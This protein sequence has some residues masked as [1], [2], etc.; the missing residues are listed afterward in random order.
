M[1]QSGAHLRMAPA[2]APG[3]RPS[4]RRALRALRGLRSAP[5]ADQ[6]WQ[7]VPGT[8]Q[9]RRVFRDYNRYEGRS[10]SQTAA[11]RS[12]CG[13][14]RRRKGA[15]EEC[16]RLGVPNRADFAP[17]KRQR[18]EKDISYALPAPVN[19]TAIQVERRGPGVSPGELKVNCPNGAREGGLGHWV[20]SFSGKYR[21]AGMTSQRAA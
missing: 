10:P 14:E 21:A 15:G 1:V 8:A 11:Q 16:P 18:G 9:T 7:L 20:L 17:T 2:S 19:R 4:C 5:G 13:L 6:P 12:G 3:L